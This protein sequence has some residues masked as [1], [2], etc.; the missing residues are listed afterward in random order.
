MVQI[1]ECA[2]DGVMAGETVENLQSATMF[3]GS[4]DAVDDG[5]STVRDAVDRP[6]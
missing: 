4:A 5:A 3:D 6:E 2:S 1:A